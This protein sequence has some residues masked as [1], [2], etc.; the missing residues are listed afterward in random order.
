M[1]KSRLDFW[2]P[3]LEGNETRDK[4]NLAALRGL[5]WDAI[6]VWECELRDLEALASKLNRF[7]NDGKLAK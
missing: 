3:K 4:L 2:A 7:L 5:G 1:P 6:V